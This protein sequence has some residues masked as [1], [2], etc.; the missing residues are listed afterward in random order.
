MVALATALQERLESPLFLRRR[1]GS[2]FL[3]QA[4][5]AGTG[6]YLRSEIL[7]V[8]GVH[9]SRRPCD[10]AGDEV[11]VDAHVLKW[12]PIAKVTGADGA[13]PAAAPSSQRTSP[14][15]SSSIRLLVSAANSFRRAWRNSR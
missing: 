3:D 9:P 6:N 2:L 13:I 7:F 12:K 10:L 4:F 15:S 11:Y 14:C 8:S 1:T 5:L